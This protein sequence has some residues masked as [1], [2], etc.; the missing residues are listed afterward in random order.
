MKRALCWLSVLVAFTS[1]G[2]CEDVF[3]KDG[4]VVRNVGLRREGAFVFGKPE[5]GQDI[6]IPVNTIV[7]IAFRESGGLRDA[8]DGNY[9]ADSRTVIDNTGAEMTYHKTWIDIPGSMWPTLMRLRLPALIAAG[10]TSDL[11]DLLK[12]WTPKG[13]PELDAA[14]ALLNLKRSGAA[15]PELQKAWKAAIEDNV[16][17]LSAAISW[18]ELG[19][20]AAEA[21]DWDTA[22][23]YYVSVQVFA[24]NWR[25]LHPL[26]LVGA[27]KACLA[28]E[29]PGQAIPF[30]EDL[31]TEYPRSSQAKAAEKLVK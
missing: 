5:G 8:R 11:D 27:V 23:R 22:I 12:D 18:I 17:T 4:T 1:E 24:P 13:D 9:A 2:I 31:K 10:R 16:G 7:R 3:L 14:V 29:Q 15:R 19:N 28:N 25:P 6:L 30:S 20:E 21:K 26:A